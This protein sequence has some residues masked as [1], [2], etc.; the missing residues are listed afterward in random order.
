MNVFLGIGRLVREP[1][2]KE[3]KGGKTITNFSVAISRT[4]NKDQTDFINCTAW[5]KTGEYIAKYGKKGS[6][7]SIQGELNIDKVDDKL[8][9]KVTVSQVALLGSKSD[10]QDTQQKSTQSSNSSFTQTSQA[11]FDTFDDDFSEKTDNSF[12]SSSGVTEDDLPF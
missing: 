8:Y 5:G 1:E 10:N 2:M 7:V 9:T 3:L 4:F 11:N 12:G 6:Q